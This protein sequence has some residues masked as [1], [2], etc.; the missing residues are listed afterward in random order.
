[1]PT[2][3]PTKLKPCKI[4]GEL[5]LPE[6][7]SSKICKKN[8]YV[9]C[10]ICQ[11]PMIW[12]TTRKVEPCSKDCRKESTRRMYNKKYG[13]D[14]PMQNKK[15]Q[16]HYKQSMM[17]KYGVSSPLQSP[18][19]KSKAMQ[20]NLK[21]FGATWAL[22]CKEIQD[23]CHSTMIE[24]YGGP[25]SMQSPIIKSKIECTM[26]SKYGYDNPMKIERFRQ[27]ASNT[28][29]NNYG[30]SNP[31]QNQDICTSAI[32]T[33]IENFGEFWPKE[34]DDKAKLTFLS[35]YGVDNPSHC[36]ELMQKAKQTCESKYGVPYGCLVPAAQAHVNKISKRN[37][38]FHNKLVNKGIENEFEFY[39]DGKFYDIYVPSAR[40]LIEI[41]PTYTHNVIG[42][43]W[44]SK[45]VK[46]NYHKDKTL[47]A[48][49]NGYRCIHV[50]DWDDWDKIIDL[51]SPKHKIFARQCGIR[52][53]PDV[54]ADE[55][56]EQYH[57][58]GTCRN[59]T[60]NLGLEYNQE[61]VEVMSFGN[62]RYNKHYS[63]ELLRLCTR[64]DL[65]VIGGASKLFKYAVNTY[66]IDSI[67]SYCDI[68]K[69]DGTV[70]EKL[71]MSKVYI[72]PPQEI[73]SKSNKRVTA[74]L[75][76]QRG[77]DQI[78]KTNYGKGTSNE[79]LMIDNGWLPVF[80]CGQA[81]Y[82]FKQ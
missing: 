33:R 17:T 68:S 24:R 25:T 9:K 29:F 79:Q 35:R 60:L 80:D 45:G 18:D 22:G 10:P 75:L 50:F 47:T 28:C 34:I 4:C 49:A 74:N 61:I 46:K 62:P 8:H 66:E 1:M 64:P 57:I 37:I 51:M 14:H 13:C 27:I 23:K 39:L 31:M 70:Y 19:I 52:K 77:Y 6:K 73:W 7:P 69:F 58:Q 5:F 65:I 63:T 76:R 42:N 20:S 78:F 32:K 15:V 40:T 41:D 3:T 11:Q 72:T 26:K 54:I 82:E 43:H 81:V 48:Q 53:L 56:F 44:N 38:E 36:A 55:F 12:N 2:G 21:K 67:I 71:G 30:A 16:L 59:K